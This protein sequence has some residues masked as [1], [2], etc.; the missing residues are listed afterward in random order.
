M[1]LSLSET[2][3]L[4]RSGGGLQDRVFAACGLIGM[5]IFANSA[6][7]EPQLRWANAMRANPEATAIDVFH[8]LILLPQIQAANLSDLQ[9]G[10]AP[11]DANLLTLI[12]NLLSQF[13]V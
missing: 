8:G 4:Y 2:T 1:A 6:A 10:A 13:G 9:S 3:Q 12:T 5:G 7:T 11:S